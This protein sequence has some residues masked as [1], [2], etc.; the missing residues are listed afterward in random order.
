MPLGFSPG[1]ADAVRPLAG[2]PS[3][4]IFSLPVGSFR[5]DTTVVGR[6]E[7]RSWWKTSRE[8]AGFARSP[9]ACMFAIPLKCRPVRLPE[10]G[11]GK[12]Q[13]GWVREAG[14]ASC[15]DRSEEA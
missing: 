2:G 12:A 14:P 7:D 13:E 10:A 9:P 15:G 1:E 3:V 5:Q 8:P 11:C 4:Q 6:T